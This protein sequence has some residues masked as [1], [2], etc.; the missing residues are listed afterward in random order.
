[1]SSRNKAYAL[2]ALLI[3]LVISSWEW[4]VYQWGGLTDGQ[5]GGIFVASLFVIGWALWPVAEYLKQFI[6]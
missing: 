2:F 1:M 3:A 6:F 4:V 5:K